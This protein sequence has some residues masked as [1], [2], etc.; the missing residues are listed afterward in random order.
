M[1]T[2]IQRRVNKVLETYT[3]E[4]FMLMEKMSACIMRERIMI[5]NLPTDYFN[6][7]INCHQFESC[8]IQ[9]MFK[10]VEKGL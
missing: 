3:D 8:V 4:E 10:K 6:Q 9:A 5:Y 1:A 2:T 7:P